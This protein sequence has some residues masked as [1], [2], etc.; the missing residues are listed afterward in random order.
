MLVKAGEKFVLVCD[1]IDW[2]ERVYDTRS[3]HENKSVHG[4]ATTLVFDLVKSD[5]LPD[6]GSQQ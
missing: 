5:Y 2:E 1:N 3:D 6:N 4:V